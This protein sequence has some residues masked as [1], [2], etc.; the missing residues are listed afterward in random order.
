ME[1][2]LRKILGRLWNSRVTDFSVTLDRQC[3]KCRC[4]FNF[5]Q[6][7]KHCSVI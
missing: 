7:G 6:Y 2:I 4:Q 1:R 5:T 3:P